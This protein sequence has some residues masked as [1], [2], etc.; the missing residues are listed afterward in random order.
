[1]T[2]TERKLETAENMYNE[3]SK[4]LRDIAQYMIHADVS[5]EVRAEVRKLCMGMYRKFNSD[6]PSPMGERKIEQ[7]ELLKKFMTHLN[8]GEG[9]KKG[10][11]SIV[12]GQTG[13][14]KSTIG[15]KE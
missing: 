14:G 1:M 15:I 6:E 10:E 4:R 7:Q 12:M 13:S 2:E 11:L 8:V 5:D 9:F 3:M